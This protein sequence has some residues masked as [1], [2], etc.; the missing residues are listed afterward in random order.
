MNQSINRS[1]IQSQ[2]C[3]RIWVS[4]LH[5]FAGLLQA[6]KHLIAFCMFRPAQPPTLSGTEVSISFLTA[7]YGV[8]A[9][10]EW[11]WWW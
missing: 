7:G 1:D 10:C 8:K 9:L 11:V 3:K 2:N 4:R 6:N 5:C